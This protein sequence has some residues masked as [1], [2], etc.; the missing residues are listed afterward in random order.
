VAAVGR[1]GSKEQL[2]A[3]IRGEL[4]SRYGVDSQLSDQIADD[5]TRRIT[6][7]EE[8]SARLAEGVRSDIGS[9]A[10]N[11]FTEGLRSEDLST[12]SQQASETV[13]ASRSHH[14][15]ESLARRYGTAG[16]FGAVEVGHA[17]ARNPAL[18]EQLDDTIM[19]M[20]LVGDHQRLAS[21]WRY[22]D[23]FSDRDQAR[24][25]AGLGLLLGYEQPAYRSMDDQATLAAREEGLRI[26]GSAFGGASGQAINPHR[27]AG[28]EVAAPA[29]GETRGAVGNGGLY[30]P[31]PAT[32]GLHSEIDEH[33]QVTRD[34]YDPTE[35]DRAR[36]RQRGRVD[37]FSAETGAGLSSDKRDMYAARIEQRAVLP[38]PWAQAVAQE[39]GGL[40]TQ[41]SQAPGMVMTGVAGALQRFTESIFS[42][43]DI[44]EAVEAAGDGWTEARGAIIDTR[45]DQVERIG[46]TPSQTAVYRN[47]LGTALPEATGLHERARSDLAQA[48]ET[49]VREE[50]SVGEHI[51]DLLVRS[52]GSRDDSDLRLIAAFNRANG[53][54]A[55]LSPPSDTRQ[56]YRRSRRRSARP[57]R[58]CGV[59]RQLQ[60]LVRRCRPKS[61][62]PVGAHRG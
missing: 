12:L 46:L 60:R 53:G 1:R 20:G 47:A 7:D 5:I 36:N 40:A 45:M 44:S 25:A 10:R 30:D 27:N 19:R 61:R 9:G 15:A 39:L 49:L 33:R 50:G 51:A 16:S 62:E 37:G 2:G 17:L 31:R 55:P 29:F 26:L 42:N 34:R 13:S 22:A 18:M 52:A 8:L 28:L 57:D 38:R 48:R 14:R 3:S 54:G 23:T 56:R 4:Q 58:G 21:E 41:A 59:L 32:E 24:A 35:V 11:V 6:S 43:G